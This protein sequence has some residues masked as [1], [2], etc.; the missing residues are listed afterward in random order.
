MLTITTLVLAAA[1]L[2][3]LAISMGYVLGWA[4]CAFHVEVD[5]RVEAIGEA[6]PGANCG[7]CGFVGCGE[8]AEAL[9]AGDT[10]ATL[11]APGGSG[12]S[13][14]IGKILGIEISDALPYRPVLHCAAAG[15]NRLLRHEY[16]GEP[17]CASANL[18]A[19][20]QGCTYGCLGLGDCHT[21][22][23]YGAISILD[24]LSVI[25]YDKCIGCRAC[26][27]ACPRNIITMVPF[28][29][30]RMLVVGCSNTDQGN[31]VKHVC[32]IGC[33][34]CNACSKKSPTLFS[35][36]RNL[37]VLDYDAYD[38][39]NPDEAAPA[40]EKCPREGL[41]FVGKPTPEDLAAVAD[42]PDPGRVEADFK[43][44]ADKTEWR[45]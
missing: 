43:T 37:P 32:N 1:V 26:A 9:V 5:P 4:N 34:G 28:K 44:T 33:I 39:A 40:L 14:A 41:I 11:C 3:L 2:G 24:G 16:R 35:M 25:D 45:G 31:A 20:V 36:G 22:C 42:E 27:R 18:V 12:C 15:D 17:T 10:E 6:L 29:A 7:G 19:G 30:D 8:Y 13:E 23:D 38:P 21:A